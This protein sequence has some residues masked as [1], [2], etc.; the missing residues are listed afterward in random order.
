MTLKY[1]KDYLK[2]R[3]SEYLEHSNDPRQGSILWQGYLLGLLEGGMLDINDYE[4]IISNLPTTVAVLLD[5]NK[6]TL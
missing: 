4:E 5:D 6:E 3:V 1:G 2:S